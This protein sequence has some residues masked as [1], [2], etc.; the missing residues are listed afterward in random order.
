[1]TLTVSSLA[2]LFVL[3]F[4]DCLLITREKA[5]GRFKLKWNLPIHEIN[6]V[7]DNVIKEEFTIT[8]PQISYRV[9]AA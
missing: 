7:Q 8:S 6:V 2:I 3:Q 4:N 5:F 1:M 9:Y